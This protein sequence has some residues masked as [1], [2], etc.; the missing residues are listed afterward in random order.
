MFYSLFHKWK[1]LPENW[2]SHS[3]KEVHFQLMS[4]E[5]H[6]SARSS[7]S[8]I[9]FFPF[10]NFMPYRTRALSLSPVMGCPEEGG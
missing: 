1:P 10:P 3:Y 4:K 5:K 7:L 2:G 9:T 6:G 8:E